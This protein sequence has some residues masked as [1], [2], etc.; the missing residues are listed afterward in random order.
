MVGEAIEQR[1]DQALGAGHAGSLVEEQIVGNDN[2]AAFVALA[3]E[4]E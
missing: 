2:R 3:E 1:A 4:L